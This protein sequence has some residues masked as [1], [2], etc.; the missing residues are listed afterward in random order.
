MRRLFATV[1]RKELKDHLRDRRSV[2]SALLGTLLGPLVSAM[3]FTMMASWYG[4]S[5]P[6]EVPVVGREHA[7]SL[8]AFLQRYGAQLTEPPEDYE[9]LLQAG[10]LDA[11]LIIPEDY[12]KDFTQ[13]HTAA[14][15]MVVD[16]SRNEA[17]VNAER[18]RSML[19][20]YS[21]LLGG[22]RLL[23][24][25][26]APELA[27]PVRVDEVDLATPERLAAR[28]LYI[29]PY[30][31]VFAALMGG[32]NV[33]IDAMAG[34]RERGSLEPLLINP[35]GRGEVVAGKWLTAVVF[36]S[37]STLVCLGAFLV[38]LRLVPLQDLGLKVHLDA[39]SVVSILA[40]LLPLSFFAS[41]GQLWVSTYARSFKEA[42]TYLQLLL[43]LPLVPSLLLGLSPIKSQPWMFAIPVFGQQ[44]LMGEV[45]R[46][47]ALGGGPYVLGA[48]G[49]FVAAAVCLVFTTRLLGQERIIFGR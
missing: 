16:S 45:M 35:V 43:M 37:L 1:F 11:V 20:S 3:L 10:K 36:A 42:Q 7:P 30:F 41:A 47:E 6:L 5:K 2:S 17:R 23:A 13:G 31:L 22:Q 24:R 27:A 32:M 21:G 8:M 48:L 49:C 40:A 39:A 15:Q 12:G 28:T 18:L 46:G 29:V 38:M 44:L 19:Q 34:E 4:D 33:A 26:V 25:G 14:V 9:A